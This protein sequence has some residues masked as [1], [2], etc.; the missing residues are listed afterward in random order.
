MSHQTIK[1]ED[2]V[3]Q[4]N[5]SDTFVRI[6]ENGAGVP[7]SH[8]IF[9]IGGSS[10]TIYSS[11]C[12]Y[13][14]QAFNYRFGEISHRAVSMERLKHINNHIEIDDD[15][16]KGNYNT[17]LSTTFQIGDIKDEISTHGW[18]SLNINNE[19]IKYYH[20][21]IHQKLKRVEYQTLIGDICLD[22]LLN[23]NAN[24]GVNSYIDIVLDHNDNYLHLDALRSIANCNNDVDI[25]I[26]FKPNGSHDRLES[27]TRDNDELI[28]YKGSYNPISTAHQEIMDKTLEL[29]PTAKPIFS[30]SINTYGKG[31]VD[32]DSILFRIK[33]I[34]KLG[35]DV[36]VHNKPLY[37][38]TIKLIRFKFDGKIIIPQGS[39]TVERF[40]KDYILGLP[41]GGYDL[42]P[43]EMFVAKNY[44]FKNVQFIL[45]DRDIVDKT[46]LMNQFLLEL[47]YIKINTI[48]YAI[49][50]TKIRN[51]IKDNH[52]EFVIGLVDDK[53]Y[54]DVI[55]HFKE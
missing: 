34:N 42:D 18:L 10:K 21:S 20:V 49:S 30:I 52:N 47:N 8:L 29:Y 54:N 51:C 9:S 16:K 55:E 46:Y 43:T 27:I 4:I 36:L 22:I 24:I 37:T 17:I 53:I 1:I 7:L 28:V 2:K 38:D 39:D 15:F 33:C 31:K 3:K 32:Y 6:I 50:S 45:A 12:Y 48:L 41:F 14:K 26:I 40:M 11:E 19:S 25:P 23:K 5:D 35:F 13:S 44:T